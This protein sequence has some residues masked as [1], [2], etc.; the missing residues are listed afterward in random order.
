VAS[1]EVLDYHTGKP[2]RTSSTWSAIS[3]IPHLPRPP[4]QKAIERFQRA[5]WVQPNDKLSNTPISRRRC[6]YAVEDTTRRRLDRLD[7]EGKVKARLRARIGREM[8]FRSLAKE[9][10]LRKCE[11]ISSPAIRF[12]QLASA[13]F[14]SDVSDKRPPAFSTQ[15]RF[16]S[17]LVYLGGGSSPRAAISLSRSTFTTHIDETTEQ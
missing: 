14:Y 9:G 10:H 3:S 12:G 2:S 1:H 16:Y 5:L 17:G 11:P 6:Q 4:V 7:D 15:E 13:R 8:D